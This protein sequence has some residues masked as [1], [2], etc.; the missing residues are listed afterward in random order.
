VKNLS[1]ALTFK[2]G[3]G[4]LEM[5]IVDKRE[6]L[7]FSFW[8][9]C[10]FWNSPDG[11]AMPMLNHNPRWFAPLIVTPYMLASLVNVHNL[12]GVKYFIKEEKEVVGTSIFKVHKD[13][14]SIRSLA[15]S[16]S[17]R[18]RGVG[19]FVL[20]QAEKLAQHVNL[21]WLEVEV[22]KGNVSALRLY[23]KFGFEGCSEGRLTVV[24]RKHVCPEQQS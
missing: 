2:A 19:F 22:L 13:T 12:G 17:K 24:L 4:C 8:G 5:Q 21:T 1:D 11:K 7:L 10:Y 23:R 14:L 20:G 18:K 6:L 16:S 9:F 3:M 15:V